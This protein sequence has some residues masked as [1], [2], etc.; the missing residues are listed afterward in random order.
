[1]FGIFFS[2]EKPSTYVYC[3][4]ESVVNNSLGVDSNLN[5]K[6]S[7]IVFNFIRLNV[8]AKVCNYVNTWYKLKA[9][10][11]CI[12]LSYYYGQPIMVTINLVQYKQRLMVQIIY[13]GKV[14]TI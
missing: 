14:Y 7:A 9:M 8:S 12:V 6:H 2:K 1:M 11:Y 3:Y 4:N 10:C 5:K 13:Y